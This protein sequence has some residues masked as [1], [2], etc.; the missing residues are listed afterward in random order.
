VPRTARPRLYTGAKIV[1]DSIWVPAGRAALPAGWRVLFDFEGAS[2][3]NWT[4]LGSAWGNAPERKEV[5]GQGLVRRFGGRWFATSM[6]GGD[7][8]P[9]R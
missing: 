8:A 9:A 6:H 5:P 1:P 4:L 7:A 3:A 2:F